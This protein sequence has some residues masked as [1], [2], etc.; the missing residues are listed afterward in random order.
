M[1]VDCG[2]RSDTSIPSSSK[3]GIG[4]TTLAAHLAVAAE[5]AKK[6]PRR[7][8]LIDTDPQQTLATWWNAREAENPKLAPVNLRELPDKLQALNDTGFAYAVNPWMSEYGIILLR[9]APKKQSV[10]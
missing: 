10:L 2:F 9:A 6:R 5:H 7:S 3:G 8:H 1:P 4:K